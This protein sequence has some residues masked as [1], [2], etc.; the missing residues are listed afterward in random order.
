MFVAEGIRIWLLRG[1]RLAYHE[2]R[3]TP[4][5]KTTRDFNF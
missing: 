5:E 1:L 4:D 2:R 3:G